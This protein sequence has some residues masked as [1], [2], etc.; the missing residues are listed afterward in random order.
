MR[1]MSGELKG[2]HD[3]LMYYT[4]GQ[5]HGLGIGGSG[6]PWFAVGKDLENNVLL[7]EQGFH[8]DSLYSDSIIADKMNWISERKPGDTFECTA[9]FRYRQADNKV[10][11]K[12]LDDNQAK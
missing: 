3:G 6:E 2:K 7:V 12:V 1:T 8:H 5:R 10:T 9:K 11:V 4:L